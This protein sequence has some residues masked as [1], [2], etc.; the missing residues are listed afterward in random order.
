MRRLK[1]GLAG[2][3][4]GLKEVGLTLEQYGHEVAQA[5]EEKD[6]DLLIDDGSES[7]PPGSKAAV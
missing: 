5:D 1:I 6:V 4:A 7:I 3:S 2:G